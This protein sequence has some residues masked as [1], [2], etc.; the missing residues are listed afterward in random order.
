[1]DN[2]VMD[3]IAEGIIF[4]GA[5]GNNNVYGDSLGGDHYDDAAI[6]PWEVAHYHRGFTPGAAPGCISVGALGAAV[7]E[8]K[9]SYSNK[10]PR[11]DIY[12]PADETIAARNTRNDSPITTPG[13]TTT[14][15]PFRATCT[16][17]SYPTSVSEGASITFTV[18]TTGI[19]SEPSETYWAILDRSDPGLADPF[20]DFDGEPI[21]WFGLIDINS[22]GRGTFTVSITAD[23]WTEGAETFTVGIY[24]LGDPVSIGFSSPIATTNPITIVDTS[25]G[26]QSPP[27]SDIRNPA[28]FK[29]RFNGTSSASPHV[30]GIIACDL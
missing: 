16:F 21:A 22:S 15:P 6:F 29:S 1:M 11:V 30:T 20:N 28:Y 4:C 14:R 5:A 10:G 8:G 18:N 25:T 9:A 27:G 13:P 3:G 23:M 2:G 24:D 17:D 19:P 26:N 7:E 12:A